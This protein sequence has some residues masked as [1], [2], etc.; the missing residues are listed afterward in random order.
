MNAHEATL[1]QLEKDRSLPRRLVKMFEPL[2]VL[3]AFIVAVV[4]IGGAYSNQDP[5]WFMAKFEERPQVV[6][7]Y[8]YGQVSEIH[9]GDPAYETVVAALN[10]AIISH[11]GYAESIH[12][13]GTTLEYYQTKGYAIELDYG[14]DVLV[15]THYFFPR[16][17]RLM[18]ALDGSYNYV[19]QQLLFR[20]SDERWMPGAI[21]LED[22]QLLRDTF[23]TVLPKLSGN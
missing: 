3:A 20:G 23:A 7:I 21:V 1:K 5:L 9:P 18:V 2:A 16:A 17:R 15:H 14:R 10:Q 12:P 22:A 19:G 13:N 4:W 8:H 6:R 11:A